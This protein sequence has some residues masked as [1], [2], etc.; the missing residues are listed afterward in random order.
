MCPRSFGFFRDLSLCNPNLS[1]FVSDLLVF[2][3]DHSVCA[4][5]LLVYV[6][7]L[8]L[9]VRDL[10]FCVHG[11]S[12]F[13]RDHSV[14][15]RD[16]LVC[17]RD[18]SVRVRDLTVCVRDLLERQNR[19]RHQPTSLFEVFQ[20]F[21]SASRSAYRQVTS[22]ENTTA[23]FHIP[24]NSRLKNRSTIRHTL[25]EYSCYSLSKN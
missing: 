25:C 3:R 12:V 21:P 23:S 14:C 9:C 18:L 13:A 1:V 17:V 20:C 16:L 6:R 5:D 7:N 2:V 8:T 22:S 24:L 19:S 15:V 11:L 10:L 4:R